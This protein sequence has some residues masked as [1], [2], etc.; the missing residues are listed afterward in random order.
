[1]SLERWQQ[2]GRIFK[3]ALERA[4]QGRAS[5]LQQECAGDNELRREVEALLSSNEQAGSFMEAMPS[6]VAG[7]TE[8]ASTVGSTLHHAADPFLGRIV[9][10]Y[11]LEERLAAGGMGVLYRATDLRLGRSVA[12]KV[13]SRQ[14]APDETAR[15]RFLREARAASA[16]DHPNIGAIYHVEEQQGELFIVMAFY[17]GETLK[18]R[19]QKGPLPVPE[20]L[21][22]LRQ[23]AVGLEAAHRAG[24]VHR[25]IK[26]AN[27][28]RTNEG[29]VKILDFGLAKLASESQAAA[30]TQSEGAVGTVSYMS[31]EQLRGAADA[32]S[33]LWS[34]G[35]VAH[36]LLTGV[37]PFQA[38]SGASTASTMMRILNAEPPALASV[39]GVPDSLA[40]L[41]AQLLRTAPD[42]R[43]QSASEVLSRLDRSSP[44]SRRRRKLSRVLLAT[45]LVTGAVLVSLAGLNLGGWRDRLFAGPAAANI[46]SLAVLPLD[47]FSRD[48]EQEYFADGMTEELIANLA[49]ISSLRVISRTSVMRYKG[50]LK[51]LRE[52][53]RELKVDAVVEGSVLRE[54]ERVRITAQLIHGPSEKHLW[55]E[56]YQRASQ[57]VLALQSEV[58]LAIA[59]EIRVQLTRD[60]RA[61]LGSPQI[62]R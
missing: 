51:P 5:Y 49:K 25:D 11:R 14:L 59:K 62:G 44:P 61:R 31:P 20:A 58:A 56:S 41:V 13:L 23:I 8:P 16:L 54:G 47:N 43:P 9:S 12:V 21:E 35:V 37:S 17:Q 34:F 24:I 60:E 40:K 7:L 48:P 15:A 22:V 18:Q 29:A 32:R 10:N 6:T 3:G 46:R 2:I 28:I 39:P 1:M 33:D 4:G 52:I 36:E 53:A 45:A 30:M 27:L 42:E 57:D 26:P 55:A 50:A 19:L 38:E